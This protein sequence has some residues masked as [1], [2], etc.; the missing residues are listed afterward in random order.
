MICVK[1]VNCLRSVASV[2]KCNFSFCS[3][4]MQHFKAVEIAKVKMEEKAQFQKDFDKLKQELEKNYETKATSLNNR[5][6]NAIERLQKQQEVDYCRCVPSAL[7]RY[8]AL[9]I[10]ILISVNLDWGKK[11][12]HGETGCA[13]RNR[14]GAVQ[15]ERAEAADGRLWKVRLLSGH[16]L[17]HA[18]SLC[19]LILTG[20]LNT[21]PAKFTKR[22]SGLQRSCCGGGNCQWRPWRTG[23]SKGWR[24][25]FP[26]IFL[27][28]NVFFCVFFSVSNFDHMKKITCCMWS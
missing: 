11:H 4:K 22:R 19:R 28:R 27:F 12:L 15:R 3:L 20:W 5:E 26:G 1:I 7:I 6:K 8:K 9:I 16:Y 14:H 17:K 24:M 10:L 2:V 13:E 25:N 23:T 21:G 18:V